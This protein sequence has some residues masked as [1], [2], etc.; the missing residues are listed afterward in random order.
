MKKIKK[1]KSA[2]QKRQYLEALNSEFGFAKRRVSLISSVNSI[3]KLTV[4]VGRET[5]RYPSKGL[6]VGNGFRKES[7]TYTGFKILG[8]GTLHKSNAVP[9]FSDEEAKDMASM[10]R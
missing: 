8:I 2:E 1:F 10:R 3:P 6:G 4:P 7:S 5:V 9:V